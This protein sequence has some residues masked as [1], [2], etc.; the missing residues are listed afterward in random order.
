MATGFSD[1]GCPL[2]E[3]RPAADIR[4]MTMWGWIAVAATAFAGVS[5]AVGLVIARV[6]GSISARL[7]QMFEDES[8]TTTPL[9]RDTKRA[10]TP[11]IGFAAHARD[12][13]SR[14]SQR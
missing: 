3:G 14:S 4:E 12:R 1:S 5:I 11:Q 7:N 2:Q 10:E 13:R 9:T 8:W 6:L